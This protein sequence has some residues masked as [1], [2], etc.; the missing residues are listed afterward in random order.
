MKQHEP[1]QEELIEA[2]FRNGSITVVGVLLAFSLGFLTHWAANPIPWQMID[3]LAVMPI[4]IGI[5]LQTKALADLM[6]INSLKRRCYERAN[7]Y[8]LAGLITASFGVA[9]AILLDMFRIASGP[10]LG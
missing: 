5:V 4:L 3:L 9:M 6:H 2:V 10:T 1:G 7:R 8:F